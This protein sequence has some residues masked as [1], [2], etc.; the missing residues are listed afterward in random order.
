MA[1]IDDAH[2]ESCARWAAERKSATLL[3]ATDPAIGLTD[4]HVATLLR[5]ARATSG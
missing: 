1:W 4:E 2:D 5:W 3:V